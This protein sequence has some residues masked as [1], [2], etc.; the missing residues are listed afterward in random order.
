MAPSV[1]A[2]DS[3]TPKSAARR[4]SRATKGAAA[5]G[6]VDVTTTPSS[7]K[8]ATPRKKKAG[9]EEASEETG[10]SIVVAVTSVKVGRDEDEA[11][12]G[13]GVTLS[14]GR[15]P[16]VAAPAQGEVAPPAVVKKKSQERKLG[17]GKFETK[18]KTEKKDED[19][20][21]KLN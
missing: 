17:D 8:R 2:P 21:R 19:S 4:Q 13:E 18:E 5:A 14:V 16:P 10:G 15:T 11:S 6:N 12:E 20:Q 9:E 7:A 1:N 3:A